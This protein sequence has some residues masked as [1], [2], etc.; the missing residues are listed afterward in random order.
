MRQFATQDH[1]S[2]VQVAKRQNEELAKIF[3]FSYVSDIWLMMIKM[4]KENHKCKKN[5]EANLIKAEY[6]KF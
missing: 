6:W 3:P 2:L 4:I 5:I 1:K